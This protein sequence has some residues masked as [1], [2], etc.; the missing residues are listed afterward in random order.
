MEDTQESFAGNCH[1]PTDREGG[2]FPKK[3]SQCGAGSTVRLFSCLKA[4]SAR[5]ETFPANLEVWGKHGYL[6]ERAST[7]IQFWGL[8]LEVVAQANR[9]GDFP[10]WH[11]K[12]SAVVE[13]S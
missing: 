13:R 6:R 8:V 11:R 1:I 2:C 5:L 12:T 7:S 4:I 3:P 10:R 9:G